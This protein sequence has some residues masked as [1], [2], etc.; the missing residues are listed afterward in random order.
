LRQNFKKKVYNE[1]TVEEIDYKSD[2]KQ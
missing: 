1:R 2:I